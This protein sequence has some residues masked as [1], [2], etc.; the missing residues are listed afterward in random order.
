[1]SVTRWV[2]HDPVALESWTVPFNPNKMSSP[3][4]KKAQDLTPASPIDGRIRVTEVD[5]PVEW[6]FSG[7]IRTQAHYDELLRWRDKANPVTITDHLG[8]TFTILLTNFAPE[9]VRSSNPTK[10]SYTMTGYVLD[11]AGGS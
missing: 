1:V 6:S 7:M 10:W 4:R 8:R 11:G 9:D 2:F 3:Y 5:Q